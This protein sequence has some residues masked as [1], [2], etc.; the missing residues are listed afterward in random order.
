[1]TPSPHITPGGLVFDIGANKGLVSQQF[2]EAGAGR[3]IAVEACQETFQ[4]LYQARGIGLIPIHAA[5]WNKHCLT[6]VSYCPDDE[7]GWSSCLPE[8]WNLATPQAEYEVPQW[9]PTVTLDGLIR[10][11]GIPDL[12]KIDVEGAELV[13]LT[14]LST[15]VKCIMFEFN[16]R[17]PEDTLAVLAFLKSAMGYKKAS[18]I[19]DN[20]DLQTVPTVDILDT[21]ATYKEQ[22]PLWG[23]F[24]VI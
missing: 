8:K 3:V 20:L 24:T 18:F 6:E 12:I 21:Y 19:C 11:F 15:K 17:F 4:K 13:V 5:A 14:G 16:R 1:M 10:V 7:G 22:D 23:M 9:V 2:L